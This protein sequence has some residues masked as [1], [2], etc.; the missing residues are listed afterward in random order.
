MKLG[1]I[2]L[3][4]SSIALSG[5]ARAEGLLN[6]AT[7]PAGA[8]LFISINGKLTS[9]RTPVQLLLRAGRHQIAVT[10]AGHQG[11]RRRVR[12]RDGEL[13]Q[14]RMALKPTTPK[15]PARRVGR[16]SKTNAPRVDTKAQRP[17]RPAAP[18]SEAER[19]YMRDA[20]LKRCRP[21]DFLAPCDARLNACTKKCPGRVADRIVNPGAYYSCADLCK[22]HRRY[23][24]DASLSAC[25]K[26]CETR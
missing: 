3:L 7:K 20:C 16:P 17:R 10:K 6:V 9:H 1:A 25:K 5:I 12:V 13:T 2:S 15:A 18:A 23:C 4:L 14:V 22:A 11:Q 19:P 8:Q 24:V 26:R 21:R